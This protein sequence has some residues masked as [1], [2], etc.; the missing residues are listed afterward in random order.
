M[1]RGCC[2]QGN[3]GFFS[4][5]SFGV[6]PAPMG[7]KRIMLGK[8]EKKPSKREDRENMM[9]YRDALGSGPGPG[10]KR[11]RVVELKNVPLPWRGVWG[12][13]KG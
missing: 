9:P 10:P 7:E 5:F 13:R 12:N 11:G 8:D 4:V 6:G 3:L 2:P 1:K